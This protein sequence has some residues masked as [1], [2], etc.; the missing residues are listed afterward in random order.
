MSALPRAHDP[1]HTVHPELP[2]SDLLVWCR[3]DASLT[4]SCCIAM[5]SAPVSVQPLGARELKPDPW[6]GILAN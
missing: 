4:Y 2:R 3:G 6:T 5:V 1:R